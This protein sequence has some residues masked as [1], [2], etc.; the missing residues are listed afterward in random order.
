MEVPSTLL[1][2]HAFKTVDY[3]KTK[4]ECGSLCKSDS[5]CNGFQYEDTCFLI[6]MDNAESL[7][8]DQVGEELYL[9]VGKLKH[10]YLILRN[11]R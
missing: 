8:S 7:V 6:D 11:M 3:A 9:S 10:K 4:I 5:D 1:N 2:T